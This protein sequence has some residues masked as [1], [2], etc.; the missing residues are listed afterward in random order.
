MDIK[1][2]SNSCS[3]DILYHLQLWPVNN[4]IL[5]NCGESNGY[6]KFLEFQG[7]PKHEKFPRELEWEVECK[8]EESRSQA[9]RHSSVLCISLPVSFSLIKEFHNSYT[10]F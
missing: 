8:N 6:S 3:N 5:Q 9:G 7:F 10:H 1:F 2:I 4:Y